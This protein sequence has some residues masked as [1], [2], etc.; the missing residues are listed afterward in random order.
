MVRKIHATVRNLILRGPPGAM[1][2]APGG[3][4]AAR[5]VTP[6]LARIAPGDSMAAA[7][8]VLGW[9][10]G[11]RG[12]PSNQEELA[13]TLL[14]FS[15]VFLR[16]MNALDIRFSDQEREDYLHAWN[17]AGHFL[18]LQ[19]ELTVDTFANAGALF[20]TL[21]ARGRA[22]WAANPRRDDPRPGL[23]RALVELMR[24]S[25]TIGLTR[26]VPVLLTRRL[27]GPASSRDLALDGHVPAWAKFLFLEA[28]GLMRLVDFVARIFSPDFSIGRLVT[29]AIGYRLLFK[30]LM[31]LSRELAVPST[32]RPHIR[33]LI[34]TWGNDKK[35]SRLM[36]AV[37]DRFNRKGDWEPPE[38]TASP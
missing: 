28:M 35:A 37:D 36:N 1:A 24:K 27:I 33:S 5:R 34:R 16:S 4:P 13:Y 30:L 14:T 18:G 6:P 23:A 32:L 25:F 21:Q 11:E 20:G 2:N 38:G 15:H 31:D 9:D 8:H 7:L 10:V 22:R 17:V 19:R 29:R 12:I 3:A 26:H